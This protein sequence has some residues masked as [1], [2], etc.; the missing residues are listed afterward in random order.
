MIGQIDTE[1]AGCAR[2][3]VD[4]GVM[5]FARVDDALVT[6]W[7]LGD[8]ASWIPV[9]EPICASAPAFFG[10]E[11]D[12]L[13]L[14]DMD[15]GTLAL[16]KIGVKSGASPAEKISIEVFWRAGDEAYTIVI[17][18]LGAPLGLEFELAKQIRARRIAE[19]NFRLAKEQIAETQTLFDL[20]I[21]YAPAAIAMFD[22]QKRYLFA[23]KKWSETFG[24]AMEPLRGRAFDDVAPFASAPSAAA[25]DQA[26]MGVGATT[27]AVL[28]G[29]GRD[30]HARFH[31][32]P[33]RRESGQS[34]GAIV[35]GELVTGARAKQRTLEADNRSLRAANQMLQDF[36][37]LV[38]HDLRAP[39]R[40]IRYAYED[41]AQRQGGQDCAAEASQPVLA[42]VERMESM[43]QDLLDHGR[44]GG[45]AA[46]VNV[47]DLVMSI[48]ASMPRASAFKLE[49]TGEPLIYAP[50]APVDIVLRNLIDNAIKH[51]DAA[52]GQVNVAVSTHSQ[53]WEITVSDDGPGIPPKRHADLFQEKRQAGARLSGGAGLSLVKRTLEAHGGS[54][55]LDATRKERGA[56]FRIVWPNNHL[57]TVQ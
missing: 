14:Q 12:L 45:A 19:D 24:A 46:P 1:L 34:G 49:I 41:A 52:E 31:C 44:T 2:R 25:L 30:E 56:T 39:L 27:E 47:A 26:M 48:A 54:I 37:A 13:A 22:A 18:R 36:A 40:A 38:A 42:C 3:L 6:R 53:G 33:W 21:A 20:L 4:E 43:L 9:D 10:L 29:A 55:S 57:A 7:R 5:A 16:P 35:F 8:L 32:E 23:T 51:H 17:S 15:S 50:F 11:R 28:A